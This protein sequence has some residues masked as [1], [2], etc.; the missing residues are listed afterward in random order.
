MCALH[1]GGT[2]LSVERLAGYH[3]HLVNPQQPQRCIGFVFRLFVLIL[4][5][6]V[7]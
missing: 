6:L 2:N 5:L 4:T 3:G 7:S 1:R